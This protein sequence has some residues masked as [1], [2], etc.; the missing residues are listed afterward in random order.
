VKLSVG[1][2][3]KKTVIWTHNDDDRIQLP[4]LHPC[5]VDRSG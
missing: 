3:A 2:T 4:A 1:V 5:P